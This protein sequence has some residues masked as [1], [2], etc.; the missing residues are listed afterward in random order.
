[1]Q[2]PVD[3]RARWNSGYADF[4]GGVVVTQAWKSIFAHF[5]A[6]IPAD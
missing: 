1:L 2:E 6:E 5:A 3:G 4:A